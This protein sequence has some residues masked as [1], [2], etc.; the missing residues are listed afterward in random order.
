[1]AVFAVSVPADDFLMTLPF[2][3]IT[4]FVCLAPFAAGFAISL[5]WK[6]IHPGLYLLVGLGMSIAVTTVLAGLA[7]GA[8]MIIA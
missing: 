6:R 8:C 7:F 3:L 2:A 1:M 4:M 5:R